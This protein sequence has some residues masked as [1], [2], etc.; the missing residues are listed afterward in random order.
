[1]AVT[2]DA[3]GLAGRDPGPLLAATLAGIDLARV[4]R[5][6]LRR[7]TQI[8]DRSCIGVG[9]RHRPARC[10][11]DHTVEYRHG[12]P[13]V[14]ADLGPL[15]RHDHTLKGQAGWTLEQPTPGTFVWTSPLGGRYE[16][17]P[18]PVLPPLPDICPG[19][20]DP[21]H[22]EAAPPG[23]EA[24]I[25]WGPDPPPHPEGDVEPVDLDPPPPF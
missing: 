12:G 25:V 3:A 24:L 7:H 20:D 5:A 15:C 16:V 23:P 14:A 19:P 10:D 18:E 2:E 21:R 11:Q 17:Q 13:T 9:C 1:M 6:A 8:R 4:P 22:E